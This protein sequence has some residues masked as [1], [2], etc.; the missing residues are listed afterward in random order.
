MIKDFEVANV[1][2]STASHLLHQME[3]RVYDPKAIS[4]I[5]DKAQKT[6]LSDRGINTRAASAQVLIDYLTVSPDTSCVFLLHDPE[7]PLTGGAKK[8]H[9]KKTSPMRV[10][11]KDFNSQVVETE[12]IPKM[13]ADQYAVACRKALYLPESDCMLLYAAWITIKELRNTIMYPELLSVDTTGD[14]NIGDR[15]LMIVAGLDNM[16]RNFPS[17]RAFLRSECQWVFHF[18]F[19]YVFPKIIGQGTVRCIKRVSPTVPQLIQHS[20]P[21]VSQ[22]PLYET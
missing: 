5:I 15:M 9:L 3:D 4:N 1:K 6:W 21:S 19:S 14:T 17:L 7:T 16:R 13:S 11:T 8:G 22:S 20:L 12:M 2:P 10:V 18:S